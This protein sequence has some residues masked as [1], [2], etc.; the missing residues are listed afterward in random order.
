MHLTGGVTIAS[1]P[2]RWE[3]LQSAYRIFQT[4]GIEDCHLM[5]PEEIKKVCP[6]INTDG[7][8]GGLWADREGYVDTTGTV[9]AYAKA[10]RLRGAEAMVTPPVRCMPMD[11]PLSF[12]ICESRSIV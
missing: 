3:W 2:A 4:I 9:H 7:V 11:W 12:S 8:I 1:A 10:A 6:I 5:T